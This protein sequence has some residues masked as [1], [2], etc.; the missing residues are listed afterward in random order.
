MNKTLAKSTSPSNV[1]ET[2]PNSSSG[3]SQVEDI[4]NF[5]VPAAFYISSIASVI[6]S[7]IH[8]LLRNRCS[9]HHFYIPQR[10]MDEIKN[11][12]PEPQSKR[13]V[14]LRRWPYGKRKITRWRL[15]RKSIKRF[16]ILAAKPIKEEKITKMRNHRS[17]QIIEKIPV[18]SNEQMEEMLKSGASYPE[19]QQARILIGERPPN[20]PKARLRYLILTWT[21]EVCEFQDSGDLKLCFTY[22]VYKNG[23]SNQSSTRNY[24]VQ[25]YT[26]ES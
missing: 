8:P 5:Y 3:R 6:S 7:R 15:D 20:Q 1:Q 23:T 14:F 4:S 26:L 25:N 22:S 11:H 18:L 16:C 2:A 10:T 21:P 9:D 13:N 24:I 17:V 12:L 19:Y